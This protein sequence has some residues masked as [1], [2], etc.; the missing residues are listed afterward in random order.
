MEEGI[1]GETGG[2]HALL[3]PCIDFRKDS[4]HKNWEDRCLHHVGIGSVVTRAMSRLLVSC[5]A[6]AGALL[7]GVYPGKLLPPPL[8]CEEGW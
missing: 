7:S 1:E 6:L 3:E 8:P 4:G 2:L 5:L